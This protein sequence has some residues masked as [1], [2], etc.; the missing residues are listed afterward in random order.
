[1]LVWRIAIC[2]QGANPRKD[3]ALGSGRR[4]TDRVGQS[5]FGFGE[6]DDRR[7]RCRLGSFCLPEGPGVGFD[8][9]DVGGNSGV[10]AWV[11]GYRAAIL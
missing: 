5:R 1:M 6:L 9:V 10:D 8:P 11:V 2:I 3:L 7:R 4:D